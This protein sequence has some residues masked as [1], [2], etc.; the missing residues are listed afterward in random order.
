VQTPRLYRGFLSQIPF[1]ESKT[2]LSSFVLSLI[3][4]NDDFT[5]KGAWLRN[6]IHH[7]GREQQKKHQAV[8]L[9]NQSDSEWNHQKADVQRNMTRWIDRT[10]SCAIE[11]C[12]I[13]E[14]L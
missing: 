12:P 6:V 5:C 14:M 13:P 4:R 9:E 2:D 10:K 8:E 11:K 7:C 1:H 3:V